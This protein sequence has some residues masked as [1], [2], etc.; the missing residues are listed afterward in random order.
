MTL[1]TCAFGNIHTGQVEIAFLGHTEHCVG[2]PLLIG[3]LGPALDIAV[4]KLENN[5]EILGRDVEFVRY[6]GNTRC[7]EKRGLGLAVNFTIQHQLD[8]IIGPA[9]TRVTRIVGVFASER[10]VPVLG[11][12]YPDSSLVDTAMYDTLTNTIARFD[13]VAVTATAVLRRMDWS[14]TCD[15]RPSPAHLHHWYGIHRHLVTL[16]TNA[17]ITMKKNYVFDWK[18]GGPSFF[19]TTLLEI[20][21]DC[22][23]E[24]A[25]LF[26]VNF[27]STQCTSKSNERENESLQC[28][29]QSSY[30]IADTQHM[31]C[32]CFLC[33][34]FALQRGCGER[35]KCGCTEFQLAVTK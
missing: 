26:C 27:D 16:N 8:V 3:R 6:T 23:G 13:A 28:D 30:G 15:Y 33:P 31:R 4:E 35:T 24:T 10:N 20:K 14:L 18:R 32:L 5:S 19:R 25:C 34:V 29:C 22:R 12:S 11:Y 7:S 17:N 21:Q 2:T 1:C 9:V